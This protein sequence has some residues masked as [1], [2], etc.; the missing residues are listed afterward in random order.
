MP[1]RTGSR[2]DEELLAA[3]AFE[4]A[5]RSRTGDLVEMQRVP[6]GQDPPD[7]WVTVGRRK[8]PMEVTSLA[9]EEDLR[10]HGRLRRL[11]REVE[12]AATKH[13]LLRDTY[14]ITGGFHALDRVPLRRLVHR[15]LDVIRDPLAKSAI[16]HGDYSPWEP[17]SNIR[18]ARLCP[19]GASVHAAYMAEAMWDAEAERRARRI[20][21]DRYDRKRVRMLDEGFADAQTSIL[22]L[23]DAFLYVGID[24]WRRMIAPP[25]A[26]QWFHTIGLARGRKDLAGR[27]ITGECRILWSAEPKWRDPE[28]CV[29]QA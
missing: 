25:G 8:F 3:R 17:R 16:L 14:V 9:D 18:M 26:Q 23:Y 12:A 13:G 27:R 7:F 20:F 11:A 22:L 10:R 19:G 2:I 1:Q 28:A 6:R 24:G 21:A 4:R 15:A 5:I 29:A